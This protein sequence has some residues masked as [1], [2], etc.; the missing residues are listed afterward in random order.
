M[1]TIIQFILSY[2]G[3]FVFLF[4]TISISILIL[5]GCVDSIAQKDEY[6]SLDKILEEMI[7]ED[8]PP[9]SDT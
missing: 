7:D 1:E 3:D 6:E 4:I 5:Y 2:L 9:D 8:F